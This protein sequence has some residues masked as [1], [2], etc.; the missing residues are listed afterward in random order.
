M[1]VVFFAYSLMKA[2][3]RYVEEDKEARSAKALEALTL[4][5][6]VDQPMLVPVVNLV[7][8]QGGFDEPESEELS[9]AGL[10]LG[11]PSPSTGGTA[12]QVVDVGSSLAEADWLDIDDKDVSRGCPKSWEDCAHL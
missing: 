7:V 9:L 8:P 6:E 3:Q 12:P 2:V 11:V 4:G 10:S 5:Q 1:I